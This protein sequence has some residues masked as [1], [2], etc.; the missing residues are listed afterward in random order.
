MLV[1]NH[2]SVKFLLTDFAKWISGTTAAARLSRNGSMMKLF[3]NYDLEQ[4]ISEQPTSCESMY[5]IAALPQFLP[6]NNTRYK[7][8][9]SAAEV[10][11]KLISFQLQQA[12][13]GFSSQKNDDIHQ[14][15]FFTSWLHG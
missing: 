9:V 3:R 2:P 4:H 5:T 8:K 10:E 14:Q 11:K 12:G 7:T 15:P 6:S 13:I 1:M